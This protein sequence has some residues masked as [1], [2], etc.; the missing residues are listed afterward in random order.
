MR[1]GRLL[2]FEFTEVFV[3]EAT[4]LCFSGGFVHLIVEEKGN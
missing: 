4:L 3:L 2:V 1:A